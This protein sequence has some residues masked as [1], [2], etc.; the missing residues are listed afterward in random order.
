MTFSVHTSVISAFY[1][2][3]AISFYQYTTSHVTGP[4]ERYRTH[5]VLPHPTFLTSE[6]D[7][8]MRV[9]LVVRK[10][11]LSSFVSTACSRA[12]FCFLSISC[13]FFLESF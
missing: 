2:S 1:H 12:N 13:G 4:I 11:I 10:R 7:R 5:G 3:F 8:R 9:K 6:R